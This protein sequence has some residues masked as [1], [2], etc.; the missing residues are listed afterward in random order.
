MSNKTAWRRVIDV[1]EYAVEAADGKRVVVY[2][3]FPAF[4]VGHCVTL[5]AST[6][7]SYPRISPVGRCP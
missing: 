6:Q 4:E 1:Y 7:P 3:D 5:F 2:N